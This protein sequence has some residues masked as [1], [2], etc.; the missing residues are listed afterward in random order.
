M[1]VHSVNVRHKG[2]M[3]LPVE[4]REELG[5]RDGGRI[6]LERRGNEWVLVRPEDLVDQL[7]G[8]LSDY[9]TDEPLQ[10]DRDELWA[11]IAEERDNRVFQQIAEDADE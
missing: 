3:T 5:I 6:L 1:V 8:S 11:E 2:Q 9:A 10:W 7:A 4:I